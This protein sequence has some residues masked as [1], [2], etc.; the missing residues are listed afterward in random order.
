MVPIK[1]IEEM[2]IDISPYYKKKKAKKDKGLNVD[3]PE[4]EHKLVYESSTDQLEPVYFF[5]LDLMNDF[6]LSP[7]KLVDNFTSSPGSGHFAEIGQRA[8]AMQ[9][10]A[11]NLMQQINGITRSVLNI[12]YDLRD[13]KTRLQSYDDLRSRDA[14]VSKA[15]RLS[16]KQLWM[17]KV[18]INKGGTS[19]KQ[20]AL[21]QAGF[22][23]L[24]DAFL[25]SDDEKGAQKLDLNARVRRLVMARVAE[26]NIWLKQSE[27]ELRKRY[28][29]ERSYLKSQVNSLELYS[30]WVRPYLIAA[31]RLQ[32]G[33]SSR[34]ANLVNIFNTIMMEL[35][36]LGKQKINV[37]GAAL[38]GDLPRQFAKEHMQKNF[39]RGYHS[40]VLVEFRFRGIP[41][42]VQQ[43]SHF[44]FGG[45]A[46]VVFK[47]Y[48]L[49]DDELAMLDK[50]LQKS[51][52]EAA[53]S[54]IEGATTESLEN[55]REEIEFYL[56]E[57]EKDVKKKESAPKDTSNPFAALFN[58][59]NREK[60]DKKKEGEKKEITKANPDNWLESEHL[61]KLAAKNLSGDEGTVFKLFNI[62]KKAHKMPAYI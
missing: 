56:N 42:R 36:I 62:Y 58:W 60:K 48:A 61:R 18:D 8:S 24:L 15:A 3:I 33:D 49:N 4:E 47:G 39:K 52:L 22:Q 10:N 35:S 16:L 26:F 31:Q 40:C 38:D 54:Y 57:D 9:Q 55:M 32:S 13:F 21:G 28:E 46:E 43:Q 25:I 1:S 59:H 14:N 34:D 45:R 20:L 2:I 51:D 19:I 23:T 7:Q 50:E 53:L 6:G 41:Q 30:R 11:S 17:D 29:L 37:K 5:I 44:S 27:A 12:L